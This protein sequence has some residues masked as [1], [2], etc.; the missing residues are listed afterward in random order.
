MGGGDRVN[1]DK[2]KG[3]EAWGWM[4]EVKK[5]SQGVEGKAEG[6]KER[7]GGRGVREGDMR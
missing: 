4:S 7:A 1:G 5:E 6:R 3:R 2:L